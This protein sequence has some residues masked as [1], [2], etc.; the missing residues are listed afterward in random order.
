MTRCLLDTDILSEIIKGKDLA[1]ASRVRA[2]PFK[3]TV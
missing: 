1:V 3:V 2:S